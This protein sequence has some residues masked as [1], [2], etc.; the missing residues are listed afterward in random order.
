M[1]HDCVKCYQLNTVYA[2]TVKNLSV[3]LFLYV[4]FHS[5]PEKMLLYLWN[6]T[7]VQYF[8]VFVSLILLIERTKF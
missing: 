4:W 5:F 2:L 3:M 6:A 8:I 7:K 1:M